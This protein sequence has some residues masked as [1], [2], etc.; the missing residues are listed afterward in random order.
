MSFVTWPYPFFLAGVVATYWALPLKGRW[1]LLLLSSYGFYAAWD[2]RFLALLLSSTA[3]DY[4]CGRAL[5]DERRPFR[6]VLV[7][8]TLPALWLVICRFIHSTF[9]SLPGLPQIES[10][11]ILLAA[12]LPILFLP[13]YQWLWK[14]TTSKRRQA[15]LVVS[16]GSN[17]G[18]LGFFKYFNF[19]ADSLRQLFVGI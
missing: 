16:V 5:V 4:F 14:W 7:A 17:L 13:T 10:S 18:A 1:W 6:H 12:M 19:F 3:I 11:M 2:P 8:T 15:F 9:P